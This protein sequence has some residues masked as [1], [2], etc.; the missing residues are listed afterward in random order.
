MNRLGLGLNALGLKW[1]NS[2]N[3]F[4]KLYVFGLCWVGLGWVVVLWITRLTRNRFKIKIK[5]NKNVRS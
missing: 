4:N 1:V 3:P 2:P 5:E